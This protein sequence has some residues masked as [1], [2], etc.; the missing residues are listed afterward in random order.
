MSEDTYIMGYSL[1]SVIE[2][3]IRKANGETVHFLA[4]AKL[5]EP[6]DT[7]RDM[8]SANTVEMLDA[9]SP[10]TLEFERYHNPR[11]LYIPYD[12]VKIKNTKN[13]VISFPLNKNSFEDE[14]EWKSVCDA[15]KQDSILKLYL[16]K[17][18]TPS[19]LITAMKSGM[20]RS[21]IDT[22]GKA[23]S[24]TRWRGIN[25]SKLTMIG[26]GYEYSFDKLDKEY[27]ETF[28]KPKTTFEEICNA[29]LVAAD[30]DVIP[31]TAKTCKKI[32]MD[33][34]F[35]DTLVV[36][37]NRIDSYMDYICGMFDRIQMEVE[38]V[39]IPTAISAAGDG[40]FYT[41]LGDEFWGVNVIGDTAY[42]LSANHLSTIY[43]EFVSEL[44]LT[45]TNAKLYNTYAKMIQFYGK[46]KTLDIN[47]R[48]VTMIK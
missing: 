28:Y 1:D 18:N 39:K 13:G 43:N 14:E 7:Y 12:K 29:M 48:V 35:T 17:G 5:G 36:M 19:K 3:V 42:K 30:I 23:F 37:D 24:T 34:K 45:R 32:I 22:F 20:P 33:T 6:L 38:P 46:N 4:T 11:H 21:F 41:P 44:P 25:V 2:A 47:Q 40:I 26:Y 16:D 27:V 10:V 9:V 8:V 15:F 31:V